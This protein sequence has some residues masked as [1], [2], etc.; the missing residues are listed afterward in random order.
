[1][2]EGEPSHGTQF[3]L[4]VALD[5]TSIDGDTRCRLSDILVRP[6]RDDFLGILGLLN[7]LFGKN[8]PVFVAIPIN[9]GL[10]YT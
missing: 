8:P 2:N 9:N 4:P 1:M 10:S 7:G 5:R 3:F 6:G